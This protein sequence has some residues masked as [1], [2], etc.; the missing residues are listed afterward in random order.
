MKKP[1][2]L[3]SR[4]LQLLSAYLDGELSTKDQNRAEKLLSDYPATRSSL[5]RL[6]KVKNAIKLLPIHKV[7]RNFIISADE[8]RRSLVPNPARVFRYASTVSAVLLIVVLTF[9]LIFP[10]QSAASELDFLGSASETDIEEK[11]AA[12]V[13]EEDSILTLQPTTL[14]AGEGYEAEGERGGIEDSD[15]QDDMLP[16]DVII[17]P[18]DHQTEEIPSIVQDEKSVENEQLSQVEGVLPQTDSGKQGQEAISPEEANEPL[19]S[20]RS[21]ESPGIIEQFNE[22]SEAVVDGLE[23]SSLRIFEIALAV[24]TIATALLAAFYHNTLEAKMKNVYLYSAF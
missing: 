11:I 16:T 22:K 13:E 1:T 14:P 6:R 19:S 10:Y 21:F 18:G 23:T 20:I 12:A 17:A 3:S 2:H 9:D 24:F 7:P 5:E 4:D 8:V 15:L